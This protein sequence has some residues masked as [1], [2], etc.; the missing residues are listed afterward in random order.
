[1]LILSMG[2]PWLRRKLQLNPFRVLSK[3]LAF[4]E[5]RQIWNTLRLWMAVLPSSGEKQDGA[6]QD[7]QS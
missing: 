6:Q 3:A 5:P 7:V 4:T 1:M 2:A